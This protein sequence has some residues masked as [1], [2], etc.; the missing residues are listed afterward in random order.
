M[1]RKDPEFS[2]DYFK[3]L[4]SNGDRKDY[5]RLTGALLSK[6]VVG[7]TVLF[8]SLHILGANNIPTA[9]EY[10][11]MIGPFFLVASILNEYG[12]RTS[13]M[14]FTLLKWWKAPIQGMEKVFYILRLI[15]NR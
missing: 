2:R 1:S 14:I 8:S 5:A 6:F 9:I 11:G 4:D 12:S 13:S 10:V 15:L 3:Y 7:V